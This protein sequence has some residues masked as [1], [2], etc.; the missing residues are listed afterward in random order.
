[1]QTGQDWIWLGFGLGDRTEIPNSGPEV[2]L[3]SSWTLFFLTLHVSLG[4]LFLAATYKSHYFLPCPI[5]STNW[6]SSASNSLL[7]T[8]ISKQCSV[9]RRETRRVR[10]F[11]HTHSDSIPDSCHHQQG[12]CTTT[13]EH[14]LQCSASGGFL[15]SHPS[16]L[17]CE[18]NSMVPEVRLDRPHV[19]S[20]GKAAAPCSLRIWCL[21]MCHYEMFCLLF[22]PSMILKCP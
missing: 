13:S 7:C 16:W 10:C 4:S 19:R 3:K 12:A 22:R 11:R 6:A 21:I 14:L 5:Y 17:R 9:V 20:S 8:K 1:M 18:T 15:A 2:Q